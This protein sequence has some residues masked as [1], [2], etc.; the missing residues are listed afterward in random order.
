MQSGLYAPLVADGDLLPHD[1]MEP[2][3]IRPERIPM[4]SYPYEW[5]FSQLRDAALLTLRVQR[6]AMAFGMSLK[7]A[8]A[9]NVQFRCG[10]PVFIDTL[11]FEPR[12]PGPWLAYRQFCEHF[13]APLLLWS[14][15]DARLARLGQSFLDGVPLDLASTLL[16]KG[17]WLR[18][19]PL[20]H[21]HLHAAA[22]ARLARRTGARPQ[23]AASGRG[24]EGLLDSLDRAVAATRWAPD[25]SWTKYYGADCSYDGDALAQ[26]V[27]AVTAWIQQVGPTAVW[28]L[29]ANTGLFSAI[30]ARDAALV[31]AF[32]ADPACVERMYRD[33]RSSR[34]PLLPLVMD[35]GAPSPAIGW[36][37][38]ERM[39]LEQ[40]GPSALVLALALVHHLAIGN[41]VP[42]PAIAAYLARLAR[43]LI[44]EFVPKSDSM[45]QQMLAGR[46]DVFP[47]YTQEQFEQ[48]FD[49]HFII[50]ARQT[51]GASGRVLFLMTLR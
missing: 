25:S 17:S 36:A 47:D 4:V 37:N 18:A 7:D 12:R 22:A 21:V 5:C 41:N 26:K 43:R 40:R 31:V 50:D 27:E 29:G 20:L 48:A 42:L 8:S 13:Y 16:P 46:D 44:I 45:V 33:A 24:I 6:R 49:A 11:S 38:E 23:V 35:L 30:A 10:R 14:L 3:T 15:G 1:E 2:G 19:G 28:D 34:L 9:Y 39:T 51:V 32:D